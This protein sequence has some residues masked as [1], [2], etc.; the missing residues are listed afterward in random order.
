MLYKIFKA[1][2]ERKDIV[3]S[4]GYINALYDFDVIKGHEYTALHKLIR[5]FYKDRGLQDGSTKG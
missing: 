4:L 5:D 2:I 1:S 3:Y